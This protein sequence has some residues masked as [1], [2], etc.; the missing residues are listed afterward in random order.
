MNCRFEDSFL[1]KPQKFSRDGCGIDRDLSRH[2]IKLLNDP[3]KKGSNCSQRSQS[4]RTGSAYCG[5]WR[6]RSASHGDSL[7]FLDGLFKQRVCGSSF[8]EFVVDVRCTSGMD[9]APAEGADLP[10]ELRVC[11]H[12]N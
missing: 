7:R 1:K 6:L 4:V 2:H 3:L 8:L 10:E 5:K 11:G 12:F 9:L